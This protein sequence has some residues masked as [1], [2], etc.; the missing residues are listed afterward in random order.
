MASLPWTLTALRTTPRMTAFSPGQSPPP[1]RMPTRAMTRIVCTLALVMLLAGCGGRGETERSE[2]QP[3]TPNARRPAVPLR[4]LAGA[5]V[6]FSF[7]G[8]TLPGYAR[9]ILREGR[10][11]G[12]ILFGDNVTS[13]GQLRALT[14]AIRRASSGH[15]LICTDQE[16]GPVRIVRFAA[17]ARPPAQ[18]GTP[19]LAYAS[20]RAAAHQ[21]RRLGIDVVLA[22]VLDVARAGG[23]LAGRAYP[24]GPAEVARLGVAALGGYR[25]GGAKATAK[26][27]PGLGAAARNTDDAAVNTTANLVPF[28]AAIG[29]GVPLV[30][31]SH[32]VY[33]ALDPG[34]IA[35]QS[36]AI[37]TGVLRRRLGFR[38]AII[39]VSLEARAV[40]AHSTVA[41]AAVR[42]L[43]A[44]A[45]LVLLTG[46]GSYPHLYLR[47]LRETRGSAAFRACLAAARAHV[48]ATSAPRREDAPRRRGS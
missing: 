20:A 40:L 14:H 12:V 11:A 24:G 18:Q 5:P 35:S 10:A 30:M 46:H 16:G 4:Q 37:V 33:P 13:P 39:T 25:A 34:H 19:A 26:H 36:R 27:F 31:V 7:S 29:A 15:A 8:T 38:G 32:A 3:P 6:V 2:P 28:R 9:D 17:P 48:Q 45:D 21:V 44:G 47:L 43:R 1:V 22:P 42:S 23:A 41:T